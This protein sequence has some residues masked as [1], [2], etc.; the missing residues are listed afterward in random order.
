MDWDSETVLDFLE[1]YENEPIIWNASVPNHKNRN[2]VYD[3][4]KRIELKMGQKY[5]VTELKKKK[6]SLMA[7]FRACLNKVRQSLKNGAGTEEVYK[8]QWFA[9]EKM[10]GFLR[11][12]DYQKIAIN[13]EVNMIF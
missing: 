9:F 1:R 6:D 2:D 7:S 4:W 10:A 12:K 11:D 8:P 3:A 13:T 5:S